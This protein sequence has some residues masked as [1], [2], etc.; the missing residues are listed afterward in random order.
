MAGL[1]YWMCLGVNSLWQRLGLDHPHS[2]A[3]WAEYTA[4]I[5]LIGLVPFIIYANYQYY[6]ALKAAKEALKTFPQ[7]PID[8]DKIKR[9]TPARIRALEEM[10]RAQSKF[11][12]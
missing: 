9:E 8:W 2:W 10:L 1:I 11:K 5:A 4:V 7:K 3:F 12:V 6:E